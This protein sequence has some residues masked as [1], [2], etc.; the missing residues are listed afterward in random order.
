LPAGMQAK[1]MAVPFPRLERN[2]I[3]SVSCLTV[4]SIFLFFR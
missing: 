3:N 4:F 2:L 1:M